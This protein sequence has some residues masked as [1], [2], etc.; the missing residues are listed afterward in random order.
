MA[1]SCLLFPD[2]KKTS[3]TGDF[4]KALGVLAVSLARRAERMFE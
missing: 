4:A 1:Y 2:R 3:L